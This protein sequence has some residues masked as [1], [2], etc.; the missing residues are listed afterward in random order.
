MSKCAL[1][2][3]LLGA[4]AIAFAQPADAPPEPAPPPVAPIASAPPARMPMVAPAVEEGGPPQAGFQIQARMGTTLGLSSFISP[5]FSLGYRMGNIVIGAEIGL[6]AGK[7]EQDDSGGGGGT[8]TDSF[9]VLSLMP[10]VYFDVWQSRDKRARFNLVGGIG[11]G[12]GKLTSESGGMKSESSAT[13]IPILVGVG[14]DYYLHRN[15]A[16]GVEA[17]I[18]APLLTKVED[19]GMNQNVKGGYE[20]ARGMLRF[21]F[22]LGD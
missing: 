9:S 17:G 21:T 3:L 1:V 18:S 6:V 19:N 10:M 13:F 11:I 12:K 7:F 2:V 5:G 4:P 8:S 14:G 22:I 16:L 15:F 20:S